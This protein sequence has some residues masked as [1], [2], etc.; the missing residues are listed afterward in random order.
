[1]PQ[2]SLYLDAETL[3]KIE[4][5]AALENTSISKWVSGKLVEH[6]GKNWPDNF[7]SL[8]GSVDDNTFCAETIKDF[9]GDIK[10]EDL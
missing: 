7:S 6:L 5:A 8:Y 3:K 2:L 1:M 10:R 9:L 4:K